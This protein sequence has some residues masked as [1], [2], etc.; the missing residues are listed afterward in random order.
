[1]HTFQRSASVSQCL[2]C[3]ILLVFGAKNERRVARVFDRSKNHWPCIMYGLG[4][5]KIHFSSGTLLHFRFR[6][7]THTHS[8]LLPHTHSRPR[9]L[10]PK[11]NHRLMFQCALHGQQMQS[12]ATTTTQKCN[13]TISSSPRPFGAKSA[14]QPWTGSRVKTSAARS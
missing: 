6:R 8:E 9:F 1:M 4:P 10:A 7:D 14:R 3:K 2:S 13:Q 5:S 11:M 12:S